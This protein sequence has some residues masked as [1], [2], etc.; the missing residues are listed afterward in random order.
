MPKKDE[1]IT[2]EIVD[3][4]PTSA[5][6]AEAEK[7]VALICRY[8]DEDWE[9][10]A[11]FDDLSI[12]AVEAFAEIVGRSAEGDTAVGSF[13]FLTRFLSEVLG[14]R[15][16]GRFKRSGMKAKDAS[17]LFDAVMGTYGE[18]RKGE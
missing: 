1:A 15:Q 14:P 8:N 9:L 10:P 6:V 18:A 11:S 2:P 17:E 7:A 13:R 12:D 5:A 3:E 4:K 16:W